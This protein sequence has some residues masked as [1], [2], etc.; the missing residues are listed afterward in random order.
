MREGERGMCLTRTLWLAPPAELGLSQAEIAIWRASLNCH[1]LAVSDFA[2][3]LT[4]DEKSRAASFRSP[5]D[6]DHFIVGRGILRELLGGYLRISPSEVRFGYGPRGK[7]ALQASESISKIGF[8]MSHSADTAVYAFSS[9]R[10]VGVDVEQVRKD[11]EADEIANRYFSEAE[12]NELSMLPP[13][14]RT[15]AFFLCWTRKE[16]YIKARGEG[17]HI[18][19]KSFDVTLTPGRQASFVR[20]VDSAWQVASFFVADDCPSA[21]VYDGLECEVR[22]F[23]HQSFAATE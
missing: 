12:L 22:Y 10:Q 13:R 21:L 3:T 23:T 6:R 20:G 1:P 8:N 17:L 11:F 4:P 7:P 14:L 15:L 19:L 16:A 5:R 18:E 9:G 2:A